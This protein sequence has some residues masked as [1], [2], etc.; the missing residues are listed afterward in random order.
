MGAL[1]HEIM[2]GST[3]TLQDQYEHC[4]PAVEFEDND[5]GRT[6]AVLTHKDL[7]KIAIDVGSCLLTTWQSNS[8]YP[9]LRDQLASGFQFAGHEALSWRVAAVEGCTDP[10]APCS[11]TLEAVLGE[12]A[13][14]SH[15]TTCTLT[16]GG[17]FR[18]PFIR[19]QLSV[20]R[21][22]AA[23]PVPGVQM[24]LSFRTAGTARSEGPVKLMGMQNQE[25]VN[26]SE[27]AP[28]LKDTAEQWQIKPAASR[29]YHYQPRGN[30]KFFTLNLDD[31][32]D[33]MIVRAARELNT[34]RVLADPDSDR[35]PDFVNLELEGAMNEQLSTYVEI[36][37]RY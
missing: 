35:W 1:T 30:K 28:A 2:P 33:S 26:L 9:K 6:V 17:D 14:E 5:A 13:E 27:P 11:I 7:G 32:P 25:F 12:N 24:V 21:N 3:E 37:S 16:L 23:G 36:K 29:E 18:S 19:M 8:G 10:E 34:V 20:Q 22:E 31:G 15:Q 4:A